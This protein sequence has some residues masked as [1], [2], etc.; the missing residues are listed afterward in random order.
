MNELGKWMKLWRKVS[1]GAL[2]MLIVYVVS[3]IVLS[4]IA[5]FFLRIGLLTVANYI[6][7]FVGYA[8]VIVVAYNLRKR[9]RDLREKYISELPYNEGRPEIFSI[10]PWGEYI[11][12]VAG[13]IAYFAVTKLLLGS[14]ISFLLHMI[15]FLIADA[16]LWGAVYKGWQE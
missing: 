16:V 9:R 11:M 7:D 14:F 12:D 15:F 4:I 6:G 10:V 2:Y 3:S 13:A 8:A 5:L 1:F